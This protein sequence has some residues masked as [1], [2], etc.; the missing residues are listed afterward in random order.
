MA[1]EV[2]WALVLGFVLSALVQTFAPRRRVEAALGGS[3]GRE[4][5]LSTA[6]GAVSSS[7]SYAAVAIAK[8]LFQRGASLQSAMAFQFASTNL[9]FELGIAI[10]V[11]LGWRFTL[12]EL[13]GGL[14]LIVCMWVL[15]RVLV[16][17]RE[18]EEARLHAQ[19]AQAGHDHGTTGEGALARVAGTFRSD[20]SMLWKEI[21]A[22]FLIAGFVALLPQRIFNDLFLTDA[23]RPLRIVENALVGPLVAA[24][25]F[26]CSVGNVPLAAVLWS[27]GATFG[28]V[29][30]FL[31][32]D[33]V[34]IPI[35]LIYRKVYGGRMAFKLVVA[36]VIAMVVASL[37]VDGVFA[38]A[39]IVPPRPHVAEVVGS[40]IGWNVTSA[41]DVLAIVIAATLLVVAARSGSAAHCAHHDHAH[42]HAGHHH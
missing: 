28:G 21:A 2:G 6:L 38:L 15:V 25:S 9:V 32:A 36:M 29:L 10:W 33:L 40:P 34:V 31:Y 42:A 17:R 8:S 35:V 22:G 24:L 20:V 7:C 16:S 27:G 13:V 3:G 37:A 14:V 18:E 11:L 5:G 23:W 4:I 1:W 26:V 39:G 30:A 12:A 19:A 41:L